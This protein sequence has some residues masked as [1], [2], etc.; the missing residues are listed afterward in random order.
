MQTVQANA[1]IS[2]SNILVTT[3]LSEG[4]KLTLPYAIAL[5]RQ[6][7]G[8]IVLAHAIAAELHL[9]V[10]LDPLPPEEHA[11]LQDAERE[12]ADFAPPD[13]LGDTPLKKV[14]RR[15]DCWKVIS[16]TIR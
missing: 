1:R 16:D 10:P 9:S 3:D 5:A 12:L 4:S 6:F 8:G 11:I 7:A 2:L 15:G 14:V 13:L